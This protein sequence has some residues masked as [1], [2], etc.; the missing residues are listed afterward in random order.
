MTSANA[1]C[2]VGSVRGSDS[3]VP[4][5]CA[6]NGAVIVL[7]PHSRFVSDVS[8]WALNKLA[9]QFDWTPFWTLRLE[10]TSSNEARKVTIASM[11]LNLDVPSSPRSLLYASVADF[12]CARLAAKKSRSAVLRD[13]SGIVDYAE[14][15]EDLP[16]P[17]EGCNGFIVLVRGDE[18]EAAEDTPL[19]E[20]LRKRFDK[21]DCYVLTTALTDLR[22]LP[23]AASNE[24]DVAVFLPR[25]TTAVF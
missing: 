20:A 19:V 3:F 5:V 10:V 6:E 11:D 18:A 23:S 4:S 13:Y 7:D 2:V 25:H 15:K 24:V 9:S 17:P 16:K 12:V 21:E 22:D 1:H 8:K 14:E